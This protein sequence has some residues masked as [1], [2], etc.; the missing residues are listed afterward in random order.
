MSDSLFNP[1][2]V[3]EVCVCADTRPKQYYPND[4]GCQSL[5]F[6][7]DIIIPVLYEVVLPYIPILSPTKEEV[8]HCR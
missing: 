6:P 1:I 2:Q 8:H 5:H 7:D 4:I 3:E